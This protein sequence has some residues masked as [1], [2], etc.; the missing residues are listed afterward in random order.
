MLARFFGVTVDGHG[1]PMNKLIAV[2][3]SY[4]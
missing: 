3:C 2:D 1:S 4:D